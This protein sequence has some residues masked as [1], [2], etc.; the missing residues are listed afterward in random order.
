MSRTE[1]IKNRIEYLQ[2]L[3]DIV[4]LLEERRGWYTEVY[5][6]EN[7]PKTYGQ[8]KKLEDYT[9]DW[10]VTKVQIFDDLL[11]YLSKKAK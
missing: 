10:N 9:A 3:Q 8:E 7:D 2:A 6:D 1:Q 5:D 4:E 11:D